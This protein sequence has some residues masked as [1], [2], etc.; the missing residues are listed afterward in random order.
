MASPAI[1]TSNINVV[2]CPSVTLAA[3]NGSAPLLMA[4][5]ANQPS[6][7]TTL[8]KYKFKKGY[9]LVSVPQPIK[10]KLE[11]VL[12]DYKPKHDALTKQL[13]ALKVAQNE[14]LLAV[15]LELKEY[16]GLLPAG[17]RFMLWHR[18]AARR[19][20]LAIKRVTVRRFFDMWELCYVVTDNDS[21]EELIDAGQLEFIQEAPSPSP[22]PP[23]EKEPA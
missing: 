20:E 9:S 14:A 10:E 6:P 1:V 15:T 11:A 3:L 17:F 12:A 7:M 13:D 8:P 22:L 23:T 21:N 5:A 19:K 18:E 16:P 2:S 4:P